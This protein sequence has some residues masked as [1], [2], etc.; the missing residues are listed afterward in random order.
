MVDTQLRKFKGSLLNIQIQLKSAALKLSN[1]PDEQ[2]VMHR[3]K[4]AEYQ[5]RQAIEASEKIKATTPIPPKP[6]KKIKYVDTEVIVVH[7]EPVPE[8]YNLMC[9]NYTEVRS[10]SGKVLERGC[11]VGMDMTFCSKNCAYATNNVCTL[12]G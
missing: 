11:I 10:N 5:I 8:T 6:K 3:L 7:K 2:Q 12:K 9:K 4:L 1:D